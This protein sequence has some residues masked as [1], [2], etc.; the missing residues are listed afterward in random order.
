MTIQRDYIL[1]LMEVL[2]KA[3]ARVVG[4]RNRGSLEEGKAELDGAAKSLLG[5]ELELLEAVGPGPIAAQ[6]G[7]PEKVDA[8]ARLVDERVALERAGGDEAAAA[9]WATTAKTLRSWA[10][11]T[12]PS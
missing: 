4:L 6:L 12:G 8:L 10:A 5:V 2:A 3:I 11:S 1:R 7:Y 9:R